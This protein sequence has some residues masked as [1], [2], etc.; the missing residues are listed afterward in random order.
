MLTVDQAVGGPLIS[1]AQRLLL[2]SAG[3]WESFVHEWVHYALRQQY[4]TVKR[5][6][7]SGDRGIDIA[8]FVDNNKLQGVWDNFQCKHFGKPI[9]PAEG[10]EEIGKIIWHSYTGAYRVPRKYWFAAPLGVGTALAKELADASALT[11]AILSNWDKQIAP[12]LARTPI[13]LTPGLAKYIRAFDFGI[14]DW[15]TGPDLAQEHRVSPTHIGRFGGGLPQ[16][17]AAMKPP[18]QIAPGE[19]R[20]VA[21]LLEAYADHKKAQVSHPNAL[22]SWRPLREHFARQR[23]AFYQAESLRQ[24]AKD[25]VPV[26]T[27]ENLQEN[28]YH[29]VVDVHDAEHTDGLVRLTGVLQAARQLQITSNALIVRVEPQD[30]SG[31]C[32]QLSNDEKLRWIKP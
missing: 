2:Y 26:G 4:L 1:P 13:V 32:H 19:S 20:Y 9:P 29:G 27:F 28:I 24:F 14:F 7:G 21:N 18:S 11:N 25:T 15:K 22:K 3:E 12:A 30:R 16:R 17:P 8:G 5:F 31:I 6:S 10:H 23:E